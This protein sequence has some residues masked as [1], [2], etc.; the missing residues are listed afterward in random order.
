MSVELTLDGNAVAGIL[1]DVFAAEMTGASG[2]CGGCGAVEAVGALVVYVSAPGT[3]ARCPHCAAVVLRIVRRED[4]YLLDL[5]GLRW[6]E[7]R[8]AAE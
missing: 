6:L 2:C 4:R 3:V 5:R 7:V 8:P 1:Q